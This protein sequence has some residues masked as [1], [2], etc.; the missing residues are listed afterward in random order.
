MN[1]NYLTKII[2]N[3]NECSEYTDIIEMFNICQ[4]LPWS[5]HYLYITRVLDDI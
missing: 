5:R 3:Y 2:Y 4:F 1:V